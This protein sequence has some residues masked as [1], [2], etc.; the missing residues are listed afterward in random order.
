MHFGGSVIKGFYRQMSGLV[1]VGMAWHWMLAMAA[2]GADF[3][4]RWRWSNPMP[5][6][7]NVYDM[8]YGLDLTVQ[9]GERGQLFTSD[10]LIFWQPRNTGVTQALLAV[11]FL[12][13]RL[14][15][16]GANGTIIY[17]DTLDSFTRVNLNTSDW[18][19]GAAASANFAVVVGDNAAIYTSADGASWTRR[20]PP[21]G[22]TNW[23]RSVAC[24]KNN[25]VAVGEGGA[26]L[27]SANGVSWKI[28]ASGT[29]QH[30]NRVAFVN[31]LFWAVGENGTVLTSPN[32][33]SWTPVPTGATN[34]LFAVAAIS[35]AVV[36]AG[37]YELRSRF[38]NGPWSNE[39]AGVRFFSAEPWTYYAAVSETNLVVLS[40]RSGRILEGFT[41]NGIELAWVERRD[42]VR[43]W[44]FEVARGGDGY[45]AVG[46]LATIL[47]SLNGIEWNLEA[48]PNPAT[49]SILLGVGGS[50]NMLIAA[51]NKGTL[52]YSPEKHTNVVTTN[53][54]GSTQVLITN[55]LNLMGLEWYAIQPR[56]TTND[57]QGVA[58]SS[59]LFVVCGGRGSIFTS[60]DGSNWISRSSGVT[61]FLS[62]AA[63]FPGGFVAVGDRGVILTSSNGVLWTQ[64]NSGTTNWLFRVRFLEG[65]LVAVGEKGTVLVSSNGRQWQA[66]S[67]GIN[68]WLND[69][70]KIAG[71]YYAVGNQGVVLASSNALDWVS[72]PSL[73]GKS[74]F[75]VATDGMRLV[76]AG[77]EGVIIRSLIVPFSTPVSIAQFGCT[78]A[79]GQA[80][81]LF[82]F[83]GKPDQRFAVRH[84]TNLVDWTEWETVFEFFDS[85]GTMLLLEEG[86]VRRREFFYARPLLSE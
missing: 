52:L 5:H 44:L 1:A 53:Y 41:T 12:N 64:Q 3:S 6:G 17:S 25:F 34:S 13:N 21:T 35:N 29:T 10:D 84:S 56:P 62:G 54:M 32:G 70:V 20:T 24:G 51:G 39:I 30:L 36:V 67:T 22:I 48:V 9:V 15:A 80:H 59:G 38:G 14:I 85:N 58:F 65:M 26:I 46:D 86:P 72:V 71:S 18:L 37:D 4:P 69:V 83:A 2:D 73:T 81:K 78:N 79:T 7:A 82:L 33:N 49:N 76:A 50:S 19:M 60:L 47:T 16:A 75:G 31:D 42:S 11:T 68:T 57:L 55:N 40:G 27:S 77:V 45:V 28:E 23:L 43:T 74:L 63:G 66:A 61:S 8:A